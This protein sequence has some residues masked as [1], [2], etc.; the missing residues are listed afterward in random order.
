[1][2]PKFSEDN[3]DDDFEF[4]REGIGNCHIEQTNIWQTK[5]ANVK[6]SMVNYGKGTLGKL[7]Q[8]LVEK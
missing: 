1:M 5:M 3:Y 2:A 4:Q 8:C 7:C 6:K